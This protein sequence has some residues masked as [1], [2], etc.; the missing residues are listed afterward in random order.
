MAVATLLTQE[1]EMQAVEVASLFVI[2]S[3]CFANIIGFVCFCVKCQ[4]SNSEDV[5]IGSSQAI[6]AMSR[7]K[8]GRIR[9]N[10][11]EGAYLRSCMCRFGWDG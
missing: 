7:P 8:R 9:F 4:T 11:G 10:D 6:L 2:R 3:L 5:V 1:P